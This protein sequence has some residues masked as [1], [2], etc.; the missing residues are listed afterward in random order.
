MLLQLLLIPMMMLLFRT[1][2][3]VS[4]SIAYTA[5]PVPPTTIATGTACRAIAAT[6]TSAATAAS[7]CI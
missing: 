5:A 3:A 7:D 6:T 4:T 2:F 1:R